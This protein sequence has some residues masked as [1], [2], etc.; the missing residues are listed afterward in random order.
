M[1]KEKTDDVVF[2]DSKG[3]KWRKENL[4]ELIEAIHLIKKSSDTV[5]HYFD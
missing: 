3:N 2:T 5:D 1:K 4:V